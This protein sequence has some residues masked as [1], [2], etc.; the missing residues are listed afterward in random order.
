MPSVDGTQ[1][2]AARKRSFYGDAAAALS[3]LPMP[4]GYVLRALFE[5]QERAQLQLHE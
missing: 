3:F 5:A 4:I 2:I 1:T